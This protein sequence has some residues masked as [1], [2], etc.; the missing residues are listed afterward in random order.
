LSRIAQNVQENPGVYTLGFFFGNALR[1]LAGQQ[2]LKGLFI[3][4]KLNCGIWQT[5]THHIHSLTNTSLFCER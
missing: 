5:S 2:S 3:A 4:Q 1:H